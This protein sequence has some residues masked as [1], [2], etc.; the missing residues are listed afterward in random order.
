VII[1]SVIISLLYM[2]GMVLN[3]LVDVKIDKEQRPERP[4]ASGHIS[5]RAAL[6]F[7]VVLFAAAFVLLQMYFGHCI[8]LAMLLAAMI[9]LYDLTHKRFSCSVVF[10]ACCRALIYVISACAV[11]DSGTRES[12]ANVAIASAILGLYIASVTLIARSENRQQLDKHRWLSIAIMLLVPAVFALSLPTTIY[13]CIVALALL[14]ILSRAALL[15]FAEPPQ[16]KQAV[17]IWLASICLLDCLLLAVLASP[18]QAVVAGLCFGVVT[19]SHR[20]IG[21]T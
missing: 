21:G 8:Y 18:V 17:L 7:I 12:S 6:I 15:V 20:K 4:I 14:I 19:L 10:M 2:A 11:V 16:T 9:V 1:L 3:D 13:P 5:P